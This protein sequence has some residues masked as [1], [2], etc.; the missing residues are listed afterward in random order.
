MEVTWG[1]GVAV[2]AAGCRNGTR[3]EEEQIRKQKQT[4]RLSISGTQ[5]EWVNGGIRGEAL[6]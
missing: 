4:K 5:D 6:T 3:Q 2:M 1:G